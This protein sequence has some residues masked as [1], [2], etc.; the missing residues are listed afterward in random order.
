M[1]GKLKVRVKANLVFRQNK[2]ITTQVNTVKI[3]ICLNSSES[4]QFFVFLL[5]T[6]DHFLAS[7]MAM[8]RILFLISCHFKAWGTSSLPPNKLLGQAVALASSLLEIVSLAF[9]LD[10]AAMFVVLYI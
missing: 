2:V 7:L 8:F 6:S 9:F 10:P 1:T 4:I 3:R 5:L